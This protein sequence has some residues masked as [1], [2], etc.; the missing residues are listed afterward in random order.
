MSDFAKEVARVNIEDE[1]RQSYLAYA[2]SVIVGRALPDVRDGLK[3]VHRRVLYAMQEMGNVPGKPRMKSAR[4][5]GDVTGKY[6]PHGDQAV[7]DTLVRMAQDFSLRYTLVD[8]QGNFGSV[9]GDPPAAMRYTEVRLSKVAMELLRDLDRDTVDLN[10][11]YD[12][13]LTEPSVMPTVV[14]N[15][16]V[17]GSTGIA[18]GMATNIPPHNLAEVVDATVLLLHKPEATVD[19]LMQH[20]RGPDFPTAGIINGVAGVIEAY[21]TGRGRILVRG[22]A[23]IEAEENNRE[24]IIVTELPYQVN[25]ARLI[26]KIAELVKE[27]QIEGIAPDLRD[28]SDKDGMRIYIP[29]KRGENAEVV[30]NNLYRLTQL[31]TVFGINMVALVGGQPKTLNLKEILESFVAHRREVVTRRTIFEIRKARARAHLLEGL[32]VALANIE[33]MIEL[34][35]TSPT[36]NEARERLLTRRW[37]PGLVHSLMVAADPTRYR[38]EEM[39]ASDGMQPDGY[40]LSELQAKEILEMRLARLTSL[41]QDKLTGEYRGLLNE[42]DELFRILDEPARLVEVIEEELLKLKAEFG[43]VRKTRIEQSQADL[44]TEDLIAPEDVVVTLSHAGYVKRQ[45]L[46][47]YRAQRRG[48]KGRSATA[49]KQEDF[50]ERLWVANTHDPMLVFT[51]LGRVFRLKV[52]QVPEASPTSRGR[53]IVNL[54]PLEANEKVQAILNVKGFAAD[55]YVFFATR[56]GVVKKTRL[57][58]FANVR[59]NGIRA[60]EL[61][62]GDGLVDVA[63]TDG[64]RDVLLFA[65]NGKAA[66]FSEATVRTMGRSARGVRGMKLNGSR[67][68]SLIVAD[69]YGGVVDESGADLSETPDGVEAVEALEV[70]E[71]LEPVEAVEAVEVEAEEGLDILTVSQNGY[72]KRTKLSAFPRKGRG[73]QGVIALQTSGRNGPLVAAVPL[74]ARHDIILISDQGTLVRTR[75]GEIAHVGRNAKGVTLMRVAEGEKLVAVVPVDVD[76]VVEG[77]AVVASPIDAP[78]TGESPV[79]PAGAA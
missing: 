79:D 32:T 14:P 25:K 61:N 72:G 23:E 53:P 52:W 59:S 42:I 20:V 57:D 8:G 24:A 19:E 26:E 1:M 78:M 40:Q 15:L 30:L 51:S 2:M 48:G 34:I 17:N 7:Y 76:P 38:P 33:E 28:E 66:R 41:E 54:L 12:E 5:V 62:E 69:P 39:L 64:S 65:A 58:E 46:T 60:L 36:P 4:I 13:T 10:P 44:E 6:H 43:D 75:A 50:I 73:A 74:D 47:T 35:K 56:E 18:V 3:P 11:N 70:A 29:I 77:E 49:V 45:P 67:V 22:K 37:N 68:V 71:V 9:D 16:L 27:K 21:R 55:R 63:L 31:Q